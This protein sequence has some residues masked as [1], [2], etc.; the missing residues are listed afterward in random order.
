MSYNLLFLLPDIFFSGCILVILFL[1]LY[2]RKYILL[3]EFRAFILILAIISILGEFY[4]VFSFRFVTPVYYLNDSFFLNTFVVYSKCFV[5]LV[6]LVLIVVSVSFLKEETLPVFEFVLLNLLSIQGVLFLLSANDL[7]V[8]Y[9]S[10]ELQS[11]SV[12]TLI[13]LRGYSNLK[14]EASLKYLYISAFASAF[15]LFG[16]SFIYGFLGV[17]NFTMIKALLS[18]K[19]LPFYFPIFIFFLFAGAFLKLAIVPFHY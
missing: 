5:L 11:L 3:L 7:V 12:Y 18:V 10:I 14:V 8:V 17:T 19:L 6:S 4:L 13:A 1:G 2:F 15:F 16:L 9:L